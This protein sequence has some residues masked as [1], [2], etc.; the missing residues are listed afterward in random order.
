MWLV[1]PIGGKLFSDENKVCKDV[2]N[3]QTSTDTNYISA[4]SL[5]C[6]RPQISYVYS[7]I[8]FSIRSI[9]RGVSLYCGWQ[10]FHVARQNLEEMVLGLSSM[11]TN[12]Q[13]HSS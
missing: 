4:P 1:V 3:T 11:F 9:K 12:I 8:T 7:L 2:K 5:C 10:H 6:G 13:D